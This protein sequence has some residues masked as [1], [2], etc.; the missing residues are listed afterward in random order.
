MAPAPL[1]GRHRWQTGRPPTFRSASTHADVNSGTKTRI[2][3]GGNTNIEQCSRMGA[4][5]VMREIVET[6]GLGV[7]WRTRVNQGLKD[8]AAV[9]I[10]AYAAFGGTGANINSRGSPSSRRCSTPTR[11]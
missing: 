2:D 6:T 10:S 11:P 1:D 8:L 7:E 9:D 3:D 5:E 4:L